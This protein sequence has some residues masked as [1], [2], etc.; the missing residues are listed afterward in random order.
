[1]YIT[2]DTVK[3]EE[4][5]RLCHVVVMMFA[6]FKMFITNFF[7]STRIHKLFAM[8]PNDL[9]NEQKSDFFIELTESH[10]LERLE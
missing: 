6:N 3:I 5:K 2:D 4:F 9:Q 10:H 8:Y 1:M 7:S